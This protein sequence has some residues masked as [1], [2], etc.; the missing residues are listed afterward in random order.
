MVA[1]WALFDNKLLYEA[2]RRL[3]K[4][5]SFIGRYEKQKGD[6]STRGYGTMMGSSIVDMEWVMDFRVQIGFKVK[7]IFMFFC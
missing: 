2:K 6:R 7:G 1:E 3:F 4:T 5:V